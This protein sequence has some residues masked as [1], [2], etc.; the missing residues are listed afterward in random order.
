MAYLYKADLFMARRLLIT[1]LVLWLAATAAG[2]VF[3]Q[4]DPN[5]AP[6]AEMQDQ[7]PA[8]EQPPPPADAQQ[9]S[10]GTPAGGD[11][12]LPWWQWQNNP[13]QFSG[14][15]V[16]QQIWATR[17][18]TL[19][20]PSFENELQL[21]SIMDGDML[22]R[23]LD[24]VH[25]LEAK[26]QAQIVR[27]EHNPVVIFDDSDQFVIYDT[28]VDT[29]YLVDARTQQPIGAGPDV[30]PETLKMAFYIRKVP[31]TTLR[32]RWNWKI[33]DSVRLTN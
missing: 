5:D 20:D 30:Q 23:E 15:F 18:A 29:S 12:N 27:V 28:Y 10:E 25:Q 19:Q 3:A 26:G 17:V 4:E 14:Q 21:R 16:Y 32:N 22:A 13:D 8:D 31:S 6:A 33:V 9:P 7:P 11:P 1:L 24:F 2:S